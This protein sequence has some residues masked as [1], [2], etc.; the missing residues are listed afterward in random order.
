MPRDKGEIAN[1]HVIRPEE[2]L[3]L[4][5]LPTQEGEEWRYWPE[6]DT[7]AIS[8]HG[9]A[10]RTLA[11]RNK[12][13][14]DLL[15]VQVRAAGVEVY[16]GGR[17]RQVPRLMLE[18]FVR[19]PPNPAM[20][21]HH[22]NLDHTHN[23]LDNLEWALRAKILTD[24]YGAGRTRKPKGTPIRPYIIDTDARAVVPD[25]IAAVCRAAGLSRSALARRCGYP[26]QTFDH[27]AR[28]DVVPRRP[29]YDTLMQ[30][31]DAIERGHTP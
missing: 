4:S 6:D 17:Y 26:Q 1:V 12:G 29:D 5:A 22:I 25:R 18:T 14:G 27:W 9:R 11:G 20:R 31:L 2:P 15:A 7:Y 8:S 24:D 21:A 10:A 13:A 19:P 28:G 30:R 3:P 23:R 16:V